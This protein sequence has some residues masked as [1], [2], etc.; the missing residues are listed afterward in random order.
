[1]HSA[2]RV[3]GIDE[4]GRGPVIGPMVIAG[5]IFEAKKI[6]G[7]ISIGVKDSKRLT[8]RD[9]ERLLEKILEMAEGSYVR[10]ISA[11]EID[12]MRKT[13]NLNQIE[14][15]EM[16]GIIRRSLPDEVHLG[17][18]DVDEERFGMEIMRLS[19]IARTIRSVHHAEDRFPAVAAASIV[20]KTTRDRAIGELRREYGDFGSGYPSDPKTR[21]FV[22][23]ALL[24]G[25]CP[26]IIRASWKTVA[27]LKGLQ[28]S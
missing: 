8:P 28:L 20:A 9:R 25:K 6:P 17:S 27:G 5:V 19:G 4:A 23:R 12:E 1:M 2:M 21:A 16:A 24:E 22:S 14:A 3:L 26:P 11:A 10:V 15:E 7:L 18:V 13:K